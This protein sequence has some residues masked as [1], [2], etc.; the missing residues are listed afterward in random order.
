MRD[1]EGDEQHHLIKLID[2]TTAA[3]RAAAATGGSPRRFVDVGTRRRRS[4][5]DSAA[6]KE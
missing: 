4:R 1:F 5:S 2:D 3:D 6:P